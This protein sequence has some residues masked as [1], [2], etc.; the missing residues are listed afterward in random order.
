MWRSAA[1]CVATPEVRACL[2]RAWVC[3][4]LLVGRG[5]T[6]L[7][8]RIFTP[9]GLCQ[10]ALPRSA[11]RRR[12]LARHRRAHG[13]GAVEAVHLLDPSCIVAFATSRAARVQS[14]GKPFILSALLW[15][16]PSHRETL[17]DPTSA[18]Q[19]ERGWPGAVP[20]ASGQSF[21]AVRGPYSAAYMR[22]G[23]RVRFSDL[24]CVLSFRPV[25]GN[26]SAR[27]APQNERVP[28]SEPHG[29]ADDDRHPGRLN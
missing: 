8:R 27:R 2:R 16:T 14:S 17:P 28:P 5:E 29:H 9:Y 25:T 24:T 4:C 21:A 13:D 3:I 26:A 18:R 22:R 19:R 1:E 6:I 7:L 15:P 12:R 23:A 11:L 10:Q 20:R